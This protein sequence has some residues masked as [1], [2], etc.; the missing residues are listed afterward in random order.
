MTA[1]FAF[2]EVVIGSVREGVS[3]LFAGAY[4]TSIN[5]R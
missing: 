5:A 4:I 2:P 3:V 1:A